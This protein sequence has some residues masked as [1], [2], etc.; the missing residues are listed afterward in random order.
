MTIIST[1]NKSEE[2]L[3]RLLFKPV[4][5][6]LDECPLPSLTPAEAKDQLA[7]WD[8]LDNALDIVFHCL[9]RIELKPE[10]Y[11]VRFS[12]KYVFAGEE[13]EQAQ[14]TKKQFTNLLSGIACYVQ[15]HQLH[16]DKVI[17]T[18]SDAN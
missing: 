1:A 3:Q 10:H 12:D 17:R 5:G 11:A 9:N 13:L 4:K 14:H 8:D 15:D 2:E 7:K 6:K 16:L 18:A